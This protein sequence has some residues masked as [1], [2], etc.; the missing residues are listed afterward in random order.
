M[1]LRCVAWWRAKTTDISGS[2]GR[3]QGWPPEAGREGQEGFSVSLLHILT[4][5]AYVGC[6]RSDGVVQKQFAQAKAA[7]A[8]L[9]RG[10][11][12][13]EINIESGSPARIEKYYIC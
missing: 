9:G 7:I 1:G 12:T 2:P 5:T 6:R 4:R 13:R 8:S 3:L 11:V 10:S